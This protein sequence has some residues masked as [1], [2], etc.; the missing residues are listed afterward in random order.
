MANTDTRIQQIHVL[1]GKHN[2]YDSYIMSFFFYLFFFTPRTLCV[3]SYQLSTFSVVLIT[4][5]SLLN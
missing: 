2:P 5:F 3:I 1:A 4:Q